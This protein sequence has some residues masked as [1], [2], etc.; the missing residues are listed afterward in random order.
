MLYLHCYV[1]DYLRKTNK[2]LMFED[3]QSQCSQRCYTYRQE[4]TFSWMPKDARHF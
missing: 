3:Y 4:S 2:S 1:L